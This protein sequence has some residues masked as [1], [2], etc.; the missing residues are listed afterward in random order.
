MYETYVKAWRND[1]SAWAEN[2]KHLTPSPSV[3]SALGE[4]DLT[5]SASGQA[6][7]SPP[8]LIVA[9]TDAPIADAPAIPAIVG[10]PGTQTI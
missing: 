2:V 7:A 5:G 8:S 10:T 1:I 4:L 3:G 6:E 9:A